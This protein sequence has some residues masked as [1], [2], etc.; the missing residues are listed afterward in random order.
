MLWHNDILLSVRPNSPK[1]VMLS[2]NSGLKLHWIPH[3]VLDCPIGN[4][5]PIK[6][7][8][9]S[10]KDFCEGRSHVSSLIAPQTSLLGPRTSLLR[11]LI[12]DLRRP[13]TERFSGQA[14]PEERSYKRVGMNPLCLL[15]SSPP[16]GKKE[17]KTLLEKL[18]WV[19]LGY[20][21]N[22]DTKVSN[23]SS[24]LFIFRWCHPITPADVYKRQRQY[25]VIR[26]LA[27]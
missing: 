20:H 16:S 2:V 1:F 17:A 7:C 6:G 3:N 13:L 10:N 15:H 9:C 19:T 21:Y 14:L 25:N 26:F 4:R 27:S 12:S 24:P 22:W 5:I 8:V 18:R 11:A 23:T